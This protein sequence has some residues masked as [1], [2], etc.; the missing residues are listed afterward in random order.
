MIW[1][2]L[3]LSFMIFIETK[4]EQVGAGLGVLNISTPSQDP[5]VELN[6]MSNWCDGSDEQCQVGEYC[7]KVCLGWMCWHHK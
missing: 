4:T 3:T 2:Y 7:D 1:I 6:L 5:N